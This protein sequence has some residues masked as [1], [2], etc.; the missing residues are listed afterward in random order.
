MTK[1]RGKKCL[2]IVPRHGNGIS[3]TKKDKIEN[4]ADLFG[5]FDINYIVA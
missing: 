5:I 2:S 3:K 4:I 1:L